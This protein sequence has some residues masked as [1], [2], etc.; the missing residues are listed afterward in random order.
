MSPS[1]D[2]SAGVFSLRERHGGT[3]L[4]SSPGGNR[5]F[6]YGTGSFPW[7]K[8]SFAHGAFAGLAQRPPRRFSPVQRC[9]AGTDAWVQ[10]RW[11]A[12]R[13]PWGVPVP[14]AAAAAAVQAACPCRTP[15]SGC[16]VGDASPGA[17]GD[18]DA[19]VGVLYTGPT[20]QAWIYR[21]RLQRGKVP[22]TEKWHFA[23]SLRQ[24]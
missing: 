18:L 5:P 23:L 9:F 21:G 12:A 6:P 10:W 22:S 16:T 4:T 17:C 19:L 24:Q 11:V 2:L 8:Q 15:R 14:G 3:R 1:C 7:Q 13:S 20:R